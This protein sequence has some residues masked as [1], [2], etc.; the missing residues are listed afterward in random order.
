MC[1]LHTVP[2]VLCQLQAPCPPHISATP[3][4]DSEGPVLV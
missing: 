1:L 2:L 4:S 3:V